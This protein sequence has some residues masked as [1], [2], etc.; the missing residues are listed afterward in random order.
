MEGLGLTSKLIYCCM[1]KYVRIN[2]ETMGFTDSLLLLV[3]VKKLNKPL[4]C[5]FTPE[6]IY[7]MGGWGW[8]RGLK[9]SPSEHPTA[10]SAVLVYTIS[11][12]GSGHCVLLK[13]KKKNPLKFWVTTKSLSVKMAFSCFLSYLETLS[14][15]CPFVFMHSKEFGSGVVSN[16]CNAKLEIFGEDIKVVF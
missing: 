6:W 5:V 10:M 16:C 3:L 9:V 4:S 2:N 7:R 1:W 14:E 15:F 11:A 8:E 12:V 13:G